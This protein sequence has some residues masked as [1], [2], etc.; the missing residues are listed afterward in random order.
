MNIGEGARRIKHVGRLITIWPCSVA[1]L[2]AG[3]VA[4]D[5][6]FASQIHAPFVQGMAPLL[7]W[8]A[9]FC[10]VIALLGV[11]IWVAGWIVEGFG[12]DAP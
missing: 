5:F 10:G 4:L 9:C 1:I 2:A 6:V 12:K 7:F 8:L 3:M 11:L